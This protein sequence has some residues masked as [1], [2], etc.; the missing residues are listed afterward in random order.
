MLLV[1][2]QRLL[3]MLNGGPGAPRKG[4]GP[5]L[6]G[7]RRRGG[8]EGTSRR[9]LG[10]QFTGGGQRLMTGITLR[11]AADLIAHELASRGWV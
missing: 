8:S 3:D 11:E 9:A 6:A 5:V 7:Q 1:P 2:R 10:C 4:V